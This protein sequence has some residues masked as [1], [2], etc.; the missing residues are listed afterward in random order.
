LTFK[1]GV[2]SCQSLSLEALYGLQKD[3]IQMYLS[4]ATLSQEVEKYL[5]TGVS[6]LPSVS[7]SYKVSALG[8]SPFQGLYPLQRYDPYSLQNIDDDS[9]AYEP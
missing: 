6:S 7:L 9:E 3:S 4:F 1:N 8:P 2:S 5:F